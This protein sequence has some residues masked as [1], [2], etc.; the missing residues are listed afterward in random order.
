MKE[1]DSQENVHQS[2]IEYDSWSYKKSLEIYKEDPFAMSNFLKFEGW[3]ENILLPPGWKFR[4]GLGPAIELLS[5]EEQTFPTLSSS[6]K[7]IKAHYP[8]NEVNNF[9][10]FINPKTRNSSQL[11]GENT[12]AQKNMTEISGKTVVS[13]KETVY[14][15]A[16]LEKEPLII[17]CDE[18]NENEV[19]S[20]DDLGRFGSRFTTKV[21]SQTFNSKLK[22][23][24]ICLKM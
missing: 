8:E 10:G 12:N 11:L 24:E 20:N 1:S 2:P 15:N 23:L 19:D 21:D 22:C 16:T 6:L 9:K 17:N 3:Q 13:D 18:Q 14:K 5:S 4:Q 7:Y